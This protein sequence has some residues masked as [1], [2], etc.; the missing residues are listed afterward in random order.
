MM[1]SRSITVFATRTLGWL[2]LWCFLSPP[3]VATASL[4]SLDYRITGTSVQV[5]PAV[6]SVPK[7]I[8]GSV[9]VSVVSGGSTNNAAVAQLT[10]GAYVQAVLRGPGFP[11]PLRIVAAP[12]SPLVLP[13]IALVGDYQLDNIA[14]VDA[15]TGQTRMEASP[16][17][18]PVH[19]FDQVLVSQVTSR[20]LTTEEIQQKGIVIDESNFRAVE[21]NVSFVLDGKTI[22]VSFPV[23]SPQFSDSTELIP[24]AEVEAKLKEAADMN[25]KIAS[26]IVQLPKD[27][28]TANLNLQL[29]GIN[30]Q[31]VDPGPGET[32]A[33]TIPPIPALMVIPGNIGYLHQFFSVKIFTENGS[34]LG[35]GLSVDNVQATLEL[36]LGPDG[37]PATSYDQPGDDPLRF[38]RIGPNK[39]IQSV[40]SV[41]DPGPDGELGTGDDVSRLQPGQTGQAEFLVE[42]L[43]EGLQV[44]NLDLTADLYGLAN[45]VVQ[46]KGKAA[47]SVLV[48]NPKFSITFTHPRTVRTGEPYTAGITVLNTGSTP[49]NLVQVSL[50]KNSISG[51]VLDAGQAETI[52]LGTILPGQSATATYRMIAQRTGQIQF[53]DLTTGDDSVSGR[54]RFTMGV[55]AQGVPLSPDTIAMP[56]YV[57]Y[58]PADL[59]AAANR[60]LGQALSISTAAQLPPGIVPVN[61]SIITRR[62]LDLAEAGQRVHYGDPLTRVLPDLLRDWQGGRESDDGFDSLLRTSDAGTEWRSVL[63]ADMEAADNLNGTG[64]LLNRAPDLAGLGQEFVIAS[65]GP[66]QLWADFTGGTNRATLDGSSQPSSDVYAGT[67]G[68][69]AVT[70]YLTNAVFTW[71]FTN[72]PAL[73]DMAVLLVNTNGQARQLRWPVASPPPDAVYQFALSDSSARLQVDLGGDGSIDQTIAANETTVDELPP[74][75]VAVQQDLTV[76]AGRPGN[77]CIGPD[78]AN[79]GTVVAVVYSKPVTQESAGATNSYTVEGNN[80]ANS[81][82]IQPS[83]RV[84]LLNLRKGISAIIPR[85]MTIT[86]VTD[87]RGNPLVAS[88]TL[89]QSFV[90]G[91]TNLFTGGVAVVGRVLKG[92]GSPAAGVPV[93]LTMYDQSHGPYGCE[94][95]IRR[96]SQVLTDPGG[97]FD[98]D[99]VMSGIPYSVSATDTSGLST[100]ALQLIMSSIVSDQP[101]A[102]QLEQIV[103]NSIDPNSLLSLLSANS[104]PQAVAVV[105]GLDRAL[106]RDIVPIGSGREGQEVPIALR[107]RGRATVVGQVVA[108]DGVTP[109]PNAAVNLYPDPASRELGRGVFSD[110]TGQ[111]LFTGVPLGVFTVDVSTSDRRGATVLGVLDTPGETTNVL[112]ALPTN[113]VE[114]GTLRGQVFDSDNLTPVPSARI[115]LGHY[116]AGGNTVRGVV[117]ITDADSDGA[118]EITNAPIQNFDIVAVTF[119]GTR[120]GVRT[121]IIPV[122]NQIVY[123]NVTLQAATTVSGRVQFDDGRPA[124]NALVAG[125]A[126]LVRSDANGNFQLEGVPV[127]HATISAGLERDPAAGIDFPRLG[128]TSANIIAGAANYVVVKLR[129]AGRI[130]GKVFDGQ[131]NVVPNVR[132]A[133]P[134]QGGF[135]WTDADKNGNYVFEN[136]ALGNYTVSAPGNAVAPQLNESQLGQQIAS[137]D[138]N[139]I[140]AAFKEAVTVFVGA[141]D[142][143]VNGEGLNF[144]PSSWGYTKTSIPFDGANVNA[145]IRY[146]PQGTISGTVLN[147]QGVPIGARVRLTGLGPDSTGE[148]V[149]TIRGDT[150]SDPATGQFIFPNVLLAGPWGLQAAS[151][152]YPAIIQTNGFTTEIDPDVSGIVLQFPPVAEVNGRIAGHVF[153]PD[154]SLVGQGA[155]VHIRVSSD[156]QILTDTNGFFDTQTAFPAVNR[157]YKVEVFDPA[158]GLKGLS[159]VAMTP[160]ITNLVDVHLLTRNSTVKVTVLQ[161]DGKVAVGAQVEL[162]QGTYPKDAPLFGTTDTN[163]VATFSGLWEGNY[164]AVAE[165]T[166]GSTR[167]MARAGGTAGPNQT[168][169]LALRLGATGTIEGTFVQQDLVTPVLGA[170]VAIGNLGFGATDTNGFFRFEG[171]PVGTYR[172]ASSD[173]VTGA[174]AV[175]SATINYNGQTQA[176][177]LVEGALGTVNGLVLDSYN[178]GFVPGAT[179]QINFSDGVTPARTVTTGPDGGFS[180]PGSP[181]GAFTL[182]ATYRLPDTVDT[183]VTGRASGTLTTISNNVSVN[184]QLQPLTYLSVHVVR[185]DGS[186]PAQNTRVTVGGLNQDTDA[187]GEVQFKNLTVPASYGIVAI[188]QTGGELHSAVQ[189]NVTLSSRGTNPVVTLALSGV[190]NVVGTVVG[191]DGST[192]VNNAEVTLQFQA[193]IF[194]GESVGALTD[195][196]GRFAFSDVPIGDFLITAAS[197]SLGASENGTITA[198]GE[199]NVVSLQL[200]ASGSLMGR[201][202]RA[203]GVTPVGGVDLAI[204]YMSQSMNAGRAVFR[205]AAD[206]R[207]RF[208]NIPVGSVH[209]SAAA[210]AFG[211]IINFTTAITSNGQV[212]DLGDVPF[213]EDLPQVV[214]VTPAD[215]SIE[216]PI[217]SPVDLLFS[218]AL[219]TN[220]VNPSGIFIRGT[221]GSAVVSTVNLLTDTNGVR[222]LVRI[223]PASPLKSKQTYQVIV[224]AGDLPGPT[225]GV[226]GSGPRDLVGRAMAASFMSQFTTADGDPPVLVSIFPSNNAVQIDPSAVPRLTFNEAIRTTNFTFTL[227]GPS[228]T[229]AGAAA[230]GINGQVLSFVP[231]T[232]LQPNANYTMTVGNVADLAGNAAVGQPYTATFATIDT[233][234][235]VIAALRIASNAPPTAGGVVPIEADLATNEPGASVRFTQDFNPIGSATNTPYVVMTRLPTSGSTTIRA[236]ATDRYGNDGQFT[237]LVVTVQAPQPPTVQFTRISPTNGPV[238]TGSSFVVDVTA[239]S[240]TGIS[241]FT[242]VAGGAATGT[243][244]STNGTHLR[245]QGFVPTNA[246]AG[247]EVQVFGQVTDNLG[248]SSGQQILSIPI[249]DAT[250]PALAVLSPTNNALFTA[251]DLLNLAAAVSDNSSNLT[252]GLSISGSITVTRSVSLAL[253]PNTQ[254]TNV[255]A[256]PLTNGAPLGGPFTARLTVTDAA[257]NTVTVARSFRLRGPPPTLQ[258]TRVVPT[259]G[260]VPSGS[261][262]VLDLNATGGNGIAQLTANVTGAVTNSI[263]TNT[264]NLRLQIPVPATTLA[265]ELVQVVA[266]ATDTLGQPSGQQSL[267]IPVRDGT[268]PTLTISGPTN[269]TLFLDG[270]ELDLTAMTADNSSNAT[271]RLVLSGSVSATQSLALVLAPN[272]TVTNHFAV[273]LTNTLPLGGPF[274]AM[275]TATDGSTNTFVAARTYQLKGPGPTLQFTRLSPA[276]GPVPSGSTFTVNVIANSGNGISEFTASVTGAIT[277]GPVTTR[278]SSLLLQIPVPPTALAGQQIQIAAEATDTLGRSSGQQVLTLT[279]SDGTPPALAILSPPDNSQLA[280]NQPLNLAVFES[281]NSGNVAL[282]F[283][284][285]GALVST[286]TVALLLT[287]NRPATNVFTVPLT[288]TLPNGGLL[289][290]SISASDAAGNNSTMVARNFWLP[291]TQTATVTWNRQAL[292]QMFTCT[293]GGGTYAWP[294]NNNWSQ[295]LV[296]GQPCGAGPL[297]P[298]Q[299]SNWS[300][301]NYPNSSTNDVLLGDLGGA[302]AN[303]DVSVAINR[304]TIQSNGGLNI[305]F[306]RTLTANAFDFQGNSGITVGGGGGSAPSLALTPGGTMTKSGGSGLFAIDPGVALNLVGNTVSVMSGTLALPGSHSVYSNDTFSAAASAVVDLVPTN[307]SVNFVG[308]LNGSG[309]GQVQLNYGVLVGGPVTLNFDPGVFQ[310]AGGRMWKVLTNSGAITLTTT[311]LHQMWDNPG[312]GGTA[313]YNAGEVQQEAGTLDLQSQYVHF[314]N[315][316]SGTYDFT[317]DSSIISTLWNGAGTFENEGVVRKSGGN[318]STVSV[319]FNNSGGTLAVDTGT[320]ILSGGGSGT[321]GTITVAAGA[322][323][324]FDGGTWSW[325]GDLSGAGAGQVRLSS[326]VLEGNP[327][328][329]NFAPGVFQWI[330]D[331]MWKVVTNVGTVTL[332]STN[333]HRMWDNPGQGGTAFYNAGRVEHTGGT[334]DLQSQYVHFYN[335]ASGT[336]DLTG[337]GSII[338]TLWNGTGTFENAGLLRKSGGSNSIIAVPFNNQG[339]TI[340]VDSGTLSLTQGDYTQSGGAVNIVLGG[341]AAGQFGQLA[342]SGQATLSG[343]LNVTLTNGFVPVP[344]DQFVILTS[345]GLSGFFNPVTVPAGCHLHYTNNAVVLAFTSQPNQPPTLQFTQI[346]PTNGPVPSGA[347]FEVDVN[348]SDDD[349]IARITAT[350]SGPLTNSVST[351][352][353]SLRIQGVVP[354]TAVPG[355]EVR[356]VAQALDNV[357]QSTGPQVFTLPVSDGTSPLVTILSPPSNTLLSLNQPLTLKALTADN[358]TNLT[359]TLSISGSLT[360]TQTVAVALAPNVPLTNSFTVPLNSADPAG[361]TVI[362]VLRASDLAGNVSTNTRS[363]WLPPS[364]PISLS[365]QQWS[366]NNYP[367]STAYQVTLGG[368]S[369]SLNTTATIGTLIIQ[370]DGTLNMSRNGSGSSLTALNFLFQ[371]DTA[372]TQSDCCGPTT[373]TLEGGTMEKT[374]GTNTF[375]IDPGITLNSYNG[376]L[377]VDSGTL[378]LPGNNSTYTD[379]AFQVASNATLNLVPANNTA[380]FS[381]TFTGSGQGRVVLDAGTV[382]STGGVSFDLPA[383]LF[384]WGGGT[385]AG[386]VGNEGAMTLVGTNDS[387]LGNRAVFVNAGTI[388]HAGSGRLGMSENGGG[389]TRLENLAGGVYDFGTDSSVY[390]NGCCGALVFDNQGLL[391]KSGGTNVS[392]IEAG[393][394]FNNLGGSIEVDSGTLSLNGG[395]SSSNGTFVVASGAVLDLTGGSVPVWSGTMTGTGAGQ[396]L[397]GSGIVQSGSSLNL[398]FPAGLFEWSGGTLAGTITNEGSVTLGGT[399]DSYLGNRSV[400]RN[401]GTI[402]HAG[403]GGLGFNENGGG[404]TILDNLT[405]GVYQFLSDGMV[406]ANGCCGALEFDNQGL[407][408][409]SGGS[410][411]AV[412]GIAFNNQGGAIRVDS[413]TLV[414]NTGSSSNGTFTVGVGA[415]VDL[416]GG[417]SPTWAGTMSGT[418]GGQLLL[419][420]GTLV[421]SPGVALNFTNDFFE[422]SGGTL[423][424]TITNEGSVTLVGT[425]DSY[426]GNR[427]VF[428]NA[429]TIEHAGSGR[430]GMSENGGGTTR[431]ENLAGGVYDFGTDSSVYANGCCGALVFDNQGLLRKSGGTNVS[432][433]EAGIAFNNLGGSIE[434][435]SGTL[436]LGNSPYVQGA[437]E[438]TVQ[439]GGTN[440]GQYGQLVAGNVT[441]SGPLHIKLAGS[442]SAPVGTQFQI[443]SCSSRS[444]TFSVEDVPNGITI[445]YTGNGVVATVTGQVSAQRPGQTVASTPPLLTISRTSVNQAMLQW[446]G[447]SNYVLESSSSLEQGALW[448]PFT[449]QPLNVTS[450]SFHVTFPATNAPQFFRLRER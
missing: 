66:G 42:G 244:L 98:F 245:V 323:L 119:D 11:T 21:F 34:P 169:L 384:Q 285:S 426:L 58:L 55:D 347:P 24:A 231:T 358:S 373:L 162:D 17:S 440:S 70:P 236:I 217:T 397:L 449:N 381:G 155:Q 363:F 264:S 154:G 191:S 166:V 76:N 372:I 185:E 161:A 208:D 132:V 153:N 304:L 301:T 328:T 72:R 422:W 246:V 254:L 292:G 305:E 84:A 63:F 233:V 136:L 163:G 247:Q 430:L 310:W 131:G 78:Y 242:A 39:I 148:P 207:F 15:A 71:T 10:Q 366:A 182:N 394:A 311:N 94:D 102:Q 350:L 416:T 214:Q 290:V 412:I 177:Q 391:R 266:E 62:V 5:T 232:L 103:G 418:G 88:P 180:F 243:L 215:T 157:T 104:L 389:T 85:K 106:V 320:L 259:N 354:P 441:L 28:Q 44:M 403:S 203:D 187:N 431:L 348:A 342:L 365:W 139:Q 257:S 281:D 375:S 238:V 32:L 3:S 344:G 96:V 376:T 194:R 212:V 116:N 147:S 319:P 241:N 64:R 444:G 297:V 145:D 201:L 361:G 294:N 352:G 133:I 4:A 324:D 192:P 382:N 211:G 173:P 436:S 229:V 225:G 79:Y 151:P 316:A 138:E 369:F 179:V 303:L 107:F 395:G 356:I 156:Y 171:V 387:Y 314:Y 265:G 6:L 437:G 410:G 200:G 272:M 364:V 38:A 280:L 308:I 219:D 438:F 159:M 251:G 413:G 65:A 446:R 377:A 322:A 252:L 398:A 414:L 293:N 385:L 87:V 114:Y 359:L 8:A 282:H 223:Q 406:Y 222:R 37:I 267:T 275:F 195:A 49:A 286:Q 121:G 434:V 380:N 144:H 181:M 86:G 415:A 33:L 165:Y 204:D 333:L 197:Q 167:L 35:S 125:G 186:T 129:P 256:I 432:A 288:N 346:S 123:A 379:G 41:V 427:A 429:G 172:I 40:L 261:L 130:F 321:N 48:R 300:T 105:E 74:S 152:F 126:A 425:N 164:S 421:A 239:T 150:D 183:K 160:G 193:P 12:N 383:P 9:L 360:V 291:P 2:S 135:Y 221:N 134:Q 345:A 168:L 25:Q 23:V 80:S 52:Q 228:G 178:T 411:S 448:L 370:P 190:G 315:L 428:V 269:N 220:S 108:E 137:G 143:L 112:V 260:P 68:E 120:K 313:L 401:A 277:N 276:S 331:R 336:Y 392:A 443:L 355:Q 351:N 99:F 255:F 97:N 22:P 307:N 110:G 67:N 339:G 140:L 56:D 338:S 283:T 61:N 325:N 59:V 318:N 396:V 317:G 371:G 450:N 117:R 209:V 337:D 287:P 226:V 268:P 393:I 175:T 404:T 340:E 390:A 189:T 306:G 435:D 326:G 213:D 334:L 270:Q 53:S 249:A 330:G 284:L 263:T 100:N 90:P 31:V 402:Q 367:S 199:T 77:P 83:G 218:E 408:W 92:D 46:I 362:A 27:F 141:N 442:F 289:T 210:P 378:T 250:L 407:V 142:P 176:V 89:I 51:A 386:M 95:W 13:P 60:V 7:G 124:T 298:V 447:A 388:E 18:V 312:Q 111:F 424:G 69:W 400:F 149:V 368:G 91:T 341:R 82:Q 170:E 374:G 445:S 274:T 115:F 433:I 198:A 184:I 146:I 273:T 113:P 128:S 73:A 420:R 419:N 54:F 122:G 47:G 127:G 295:S 335:L 423:A 16:S 327:V 262:L 43:Q 57:N 357:S 202:V 1:N 224:L 174:N 206:G 253:T 188:S 158:S 279:V 271:L 439:L 409:K 353:S 248:L 237:Q 230:V 36:P 75:L 227:T 29:Q 399:N 309:A 235:P 50:N 216:V 343:P 93:T 417:G 118:W 299:P 196:Q 205:T 20:P 26:E 405:S 234:G 45:G 302:P 332:A 278:S 81:V 101:S 19:V 296:L 258:I 349:G 109:V 30:F 329:L 240:D 14:L